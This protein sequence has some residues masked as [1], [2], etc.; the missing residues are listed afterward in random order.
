MI[1]RILKRIKFRRTIKS[2]ESTNVVDGMVKARQLYKELSKISHPDRNPEFSD[3]A[4]ELMQRI[5]AN[6]FNYAALLLLKQEVI[7][8]LHNP[9]YLSENQV[10]INVQQK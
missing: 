9:I 7:E 4:E 3:V 6:R 1:L 5:V 2:D 10:L 8:K